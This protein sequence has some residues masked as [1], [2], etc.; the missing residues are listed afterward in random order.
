[1][2]PSYVSV[3]FQHNRLRYSRRSPLTVIDKP[4]RGGSV[5]FQQNLHQCCRRQPPIAMAQPK[6]GPQSAEC[7]DLPQTMTP[8]Y[9][10]VCFQHNRL[11][12]SRRSP[13]TAIDKPKSVAPSGFNKIFTNVAG[14][15]LQQQWLNQNGGLSR[16][17]DIWKNDD[18]MCFDVDNNL[19]KDE[20]IYKLPEFCGVRM[21]VV[22]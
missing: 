3:C 13:L 9:V 8:S 17:Y 15:S 1:M 6:W 2:A 4:K 16:V 18:G 22:E 5:W 11:R 19:C 7:V 20:G 10:S 12:Y 14:V 21:A